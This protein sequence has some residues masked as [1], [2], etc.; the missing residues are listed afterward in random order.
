MSRPP[1][2]KHVVL[3][4]MCF[5]TAR[6]G[7]S[8]ARGETGARGDARATLLQSIIP[9]GVNAS[10][11]RIRFHRLSQGAAARAAPLLATMVNVL[12]MLAPRLN[13]SQWSS[14]SFGA[15]RLHRMLFGMKAQFRE[16]A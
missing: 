16:G 2:G 7:S 1:R 13:L 11:R 12:E 5:L 10:A 4:L 15:G 9:R 8:G 14:G 3:G 6:N